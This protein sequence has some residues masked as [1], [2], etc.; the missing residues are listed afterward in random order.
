VINKQSATDL[1]ALINQFQS[2]LN[3]KEALNLSI[4]LHEVLLSQI[5]IEHVDEVT[6]KQWEMQAVSQRMIELEAI[7]KLLEGKC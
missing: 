6:R 5:L 2:N 7:I 4:P 3:A 1:R